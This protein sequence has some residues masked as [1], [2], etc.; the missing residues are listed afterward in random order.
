MSSSEPRHA[1]IIEAQRNSYCREFQ[2]RVVRCDVD[3][4]DVLVELE[5][6]ILHPTGGGQP[7]DYG[8]LSAPDQSWQVRVSDVFYVN[9]NSNSS[10]NLNSNSNS[11]SNSG[12]VIHRVKSCAL[13]SL[14]CGQLVLVAVDWRRRFDHMQQHSAQ[15]LISALARRLHRWETVGWTLSPLNQIC[16]I[17]LRASPGGGSAPSR[18]NRERL[19]NA[20]NEAIREASCVDVSVDEASS[21]RT[22]NIRV[23]DDRNH[24]CGTHV[25]S[26][27]HLQAVHLL[28]VV[29]RQNGTMVLPFLAGDRLL[30]RLDD[31]LRVERAVNAELSVGTPLFVDKIRQ[32]N[33]ERKT[34]LKQADALRAQLAA[35]EVQSLVQRA[36]DEQVVVALR[37]DD[38]GALKTL[39]AAFSRAAPDAVLVAFAKRTGALF[40]IGPKNL[41][42]PQTARR[43]GAR[44]SARGGG[45]P[46]RFQG[47]VAQANIHAALEQLSELPSFILNAESASSSS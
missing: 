34:A 11:N 43:I 2:T 16:T 46:G 25:A 19:A 36:Q 14:Q 38:I 40:M 27:A 47:V 9:S 13:S 7:C 32:V 21:L 24:C 29:A 39:G 8:T 20:V 22:V 10:S 15:H 17:D 33:A 37:D 4:D 28:D 45:P 6:T 18:E 41:L 26:T 31:L 30:A 3:G 12:R 1:I 23:I 5:D 44:L 35:F 42:P